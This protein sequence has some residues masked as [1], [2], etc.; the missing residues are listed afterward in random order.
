MSE[1]KL[2]KTISYAIAALTPLCFERRDGSGR[3][4]R[5]PE[6]PCSEFVTRVVIRED[7][8]EEETCLPKSRLQI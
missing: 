5:G 8:P 3:L 4:R 2:T 6:T 1:A 7:T